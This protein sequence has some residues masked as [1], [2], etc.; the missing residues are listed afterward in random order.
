M[1]WRST[2][3]ARVAPTTLCK[4]SHHTRGNTQPTSVADTDAVRSAACQAFADFWREAEQAIAAITPSA[5]ATLAELERSGYAEAVA[6][7]DGVAHHCSA[8]SAELT[9][10]PTTGALVGLHDSAYLSHTP[11]FVFIKGRFKGLT[12]VPFLDI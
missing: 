9:F 2:A 5:P 11:E 7:E 4:R 1:N 10:D 12:S 8:A 3:C 6:V